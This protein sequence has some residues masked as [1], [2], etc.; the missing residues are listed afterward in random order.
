ML[1]DRELDWREW[2]RLVVCIIAMNWIAVMA[3]LFVILLHNGIF[4]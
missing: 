4:N 3:L 2:L 1:E